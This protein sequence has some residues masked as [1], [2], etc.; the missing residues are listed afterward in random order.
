M[1]QARVANARVRRPSCFVSLPLRL[2]MVLHYYVRSP[3]LGDVGDH[4]V[5]VGQ[6]V[7]GHGQDVGD[8][9]R[10]MVRIMAGI[11]AGILGVAHTGKRCVVVC[12]SEVYG[13]AWDCRKGVVLGDVGEDGRDDGQ[14]HV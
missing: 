6:D 2:L 13:R 7:G 9:V 1:Q 14:G 8:M 3:L 5:D 10:M 11:M 12:V 4:G